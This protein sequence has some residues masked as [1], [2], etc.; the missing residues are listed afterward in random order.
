MLEKEAKINQLFADLHRDNIR[1]LVT[2][3]DCLE[4]DMCLHKI[5]NLDA[6]QARVLLETPNSHL[7]ELLHSGARVPLFSLKCS[8]EELQQIISAAQEE[9]TRCISTDILLTCEGR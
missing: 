4:L 6:E 9:A 7:A 8:G 2:I 1:M 3:K 5:F